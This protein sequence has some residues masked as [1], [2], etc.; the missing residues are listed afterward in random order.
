[1]GKKIVLSIRNTINKLIFVFKTDIMA[2]LEDFQKQYDLINEAIA[3]LGNITTDLEALKKSIADTAAAGMT[4]EEQDTALST[5]TNIVSALQ[6]LVP[7]TEPSTTE[8]PV[9]PPAEPTAQ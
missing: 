3:Q 2:K 8:A 6:I 9:T 4:P 7:A 1:M 5:L